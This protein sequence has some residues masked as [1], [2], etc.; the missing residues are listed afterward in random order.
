[1]N[2]EI[3]LH[4]I[5]IYYLAVYCLSLVIGLMVS[6]QLDARLGHLGVATANGIIDSWCLMRGWVNGLARL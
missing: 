1:M 6:L 4:C 5:L 2:K 3:P